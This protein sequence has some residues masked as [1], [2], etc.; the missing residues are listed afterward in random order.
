MGLFIQM[1]GGRLKKLRN[2][3]GGPKAEKGYRKWLDVWHSRQP[4]WQQAI[5]PIE[6]TKVEEPTTAA[7]LAAASYNGNGIILMRFCDGKI[8]AEKI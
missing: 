6:P 3:R 4:R 8:I 2:R 7:T 5:E 1:P